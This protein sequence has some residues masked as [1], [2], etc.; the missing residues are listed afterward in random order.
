MKRALQLLLAVVLIGGVVA[1]MM[2]NKSFDDVEQL[3]VDFILPAP[4][5]FADYESDEAKANERYNDKVL[6]VTG[7]VLESS[8]DEDGIVKVVLESDG[9]FGVV[10][11]LD[12]LTEHKRTD[13]ETGE[14]VTFKG[15]CTGYL[16]DVVLVR[17]VE[18]LE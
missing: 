17:C 10:C 15:L 4:A 11:K 6:Q 14:D 12:E 18:V 2:Y 16:S 1:Y 9:M 13:F 3:K 5:L 8:T 7:K